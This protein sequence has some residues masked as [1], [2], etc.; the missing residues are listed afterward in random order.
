MTQQINPITQRPYK[1]R[2]NPGA[3]RGAI[4]FGSRLSKAGDLI[5]RAGVRSF[6]TDQRYLIEVNTRTG[7]ARCECEA[8]RRQI[9]RSGVYPNLADIE[10]TGY[11]KHLREWWQE[12][13]QEVI[14]R[15]QEAGR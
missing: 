12:L 10:R 3:A 9:E 4:M 6:K 13:A 5:L 1:G 14:E 15:N 11:C 2:C 7:E 8:C